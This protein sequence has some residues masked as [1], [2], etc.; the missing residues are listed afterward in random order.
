MAIAK[1]RE[2]E[3]VRMVQEKYTELEG[4]T[5]ELTD[6]EA[7]A[8]KAVVGSVGGD[9]KYRGA[10]TRIWNA[11]NRAGYDSRSNAKVSAAIS[12]LSGSVY[13]E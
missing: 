3:K 10:I 8:L 6:E 5:L 2:V 11:F 12:N 1:A 7:V 4:V 13:F 9:S